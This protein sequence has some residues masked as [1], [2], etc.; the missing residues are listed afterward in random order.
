MARIGRVKVDYKPRDEYYTPNW[1]FAELGLQFDLDPAHPDF[2]TNVPTNKYF[3]K[4]DNGL[5][6]EWVGRIWM[7]PPFSESK[8]WVHKF[9]AHRN[10]IAL[11]PFAKSLWFNEIW[12]DA[13]AVLPLPYNIRFEYEGKVNGSIFLP[14]GL[15]AYGL[16]NVEAL[17]RLNKGRVR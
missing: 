13:E 2:P 7:N 4:D 14:V 6:K 17:K 1:I 8:L 12:N 11:L 15:F 10:G 9:M 16:V 5:E 3:T